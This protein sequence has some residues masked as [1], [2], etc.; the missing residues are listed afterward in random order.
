MNLMRELMEDSKPLTLVW[1]LK[2]NWNDKLLQASTGSCLQLV[3][4]QMKYET[5]GVLKRGDLDKKI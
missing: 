1:K 2:L 3:K 5:H 4:D